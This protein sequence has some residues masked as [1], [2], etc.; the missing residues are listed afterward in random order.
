MAMKQQAIA[1]VPGEHRREV[2]VGRG[3]DHPL[4]APEVLMSLRAAAERGE[5]ARGD[6]GMV[7]LVFTDPVGSS[8]LDAA[9]G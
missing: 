7:M 5:I 1:A 4:R 3:D 9:T 8:H 6:K 2:V